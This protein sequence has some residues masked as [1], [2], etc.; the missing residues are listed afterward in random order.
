MSEPLMPVFHLNNAY[1]LS[2]FLYTVRRVRFEV[3][4]QGHDDRLLGRDLIF[5][6]LFDKPIAC[7]YS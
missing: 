3:S 7:L 6:N 5:T 2:C 1:R 4:R